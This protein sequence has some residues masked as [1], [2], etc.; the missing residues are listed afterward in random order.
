VSTEDPE[1][2]RVAELLLLQR[3]GGLD[4]AEQIELA[5][6]RDEHPEL[7]PAAEALAGEAERVTALG[8]GWLARVEADKALRKAESTPWTRRERVAGAVLLVGGWLATIT[9]AA[10]GPA[11]ALT[12]FAILLASLI[13]VR[14][15]RGHRDPYDDIK[16]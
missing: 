8:H 7:L 9:G 14:L 10:I 4:E 1:R 11:L 5:L 13:R 3:D 12:G 2:R 16:Q 6:Y 15:A